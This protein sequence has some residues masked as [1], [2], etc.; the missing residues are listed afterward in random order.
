MASSPEFKMAQQ[1]V[2]K[3]GEHKDKTLDKA[4]ETDRGL[5][6]LDWLNGQEWVKEPLKTH[7]RNYLTDPTI[8]KEV[9]E[10]NERKKHSR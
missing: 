10:A 2:L 9:D 4:A 8:K 5:L 1:Y 3:F 7:L 6:Y